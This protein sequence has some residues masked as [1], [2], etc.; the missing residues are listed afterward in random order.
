VRRSG[1]KA[2][3]VATFADL[4]RGEMFYTVEESLNIMAIRLNRGL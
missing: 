4:H 2:V 3:S 1:L